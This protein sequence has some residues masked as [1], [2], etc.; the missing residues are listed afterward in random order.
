MELIYAILL[1]PVGITLFIWCCCCAEA[2]S[3]RGRNSGGW[4]FAA[5]FCSPI[6]A[7]VILIALGDTQKKENKRYCVMKS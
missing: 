3:D 2:A 7:A 1:I 6:L 5:F 4:F